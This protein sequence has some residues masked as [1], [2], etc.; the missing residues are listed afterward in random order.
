MYSSKLRFSYVFCEIS[1]YQNTALGSINILWKDR[2]VW[3]VYVLVN[4]DSVICFI[5]DFLH[6]KYSLRTILGPFSYLESRLN[7]T[8]RCYDNVLV[9][10]YLKD[11]NIYDSSL[12]VT[13]KDHNS[14]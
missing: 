4:L 9:N 14:I 1:V 11:E 10:V 3:L 12:I 7:W 13:T 2:N 6:I 8:N 5:K